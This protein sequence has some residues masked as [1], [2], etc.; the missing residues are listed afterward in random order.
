[1]ISYHDLYITTEHISRTKLFNLSFSLMVICT[2]TGGWE[3]WDMRGGF[4][5]S[6]LVA[7]EYAKNWL[8]LED[9][10]HVIIDSRKK[11]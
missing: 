10:D 2:R 8:V 3:L 1:M 9:G 5:N 4:Q 6:E 11:D 7:G